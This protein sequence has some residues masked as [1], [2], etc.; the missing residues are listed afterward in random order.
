[1]PTS[2]FS[3]ATHF[4]GIT[5]VHGSLD[6][7]KILE[8]FRISGHGEIKHDET[9]WCAAFVGACLRL[10][11]YRSTGSLA[12]RSYEKFGDDLK[13]EPKRGSIVVFW[14]GSPSADTGHVAFYD[15]DEGDHV[16]VLGG[17][18]GN[19]VTLASFPKSRVLGYRW[20]S[21]I[22]QLPTDTTLPN[23]LAIDPDSAPPHVLGIGG[24]GAGRRR[25][26]RATEI[27]TEGAQGPAVRALQ[28]ALSGQGFQVGEVDGEFG[29][30]TRGAVAEFQRSRSLPAT[31]DADEATLQALGIA[32]PR[33]LVSVREGPPISGGGITTMQP[34]DILKIVV[35][36]L[37][38]SRGAGVAGPTPTPAPGTLGADQLLQAVL[39]ALTGQPQPPGKVDAPLPEAPST[40]PVVLSWID[41]I[42]GGEALAGKKTAL[43]VVAYVILAILQAVGVAGTATGTTATQTGQILTMLIG[44]FGTLGGISKIDRV[45]QILGMIAGRSS[46]QLK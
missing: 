38:A 33:R 25:E 15:H 13:D 17:N 3:V 42:F 21:E 19:A 29:P 34:Q 27:L 23:I 39:T 18:Q 6:N 5:E 30:L 45:L 10:A 44:A 32:P 43:A 36:A 37:I 7:P 20:P 22:A 26:P 4:R 12:A 9:P 2:W 11:G 46:A 16:V 31:G 1:M 35:D 8:M 24:N 14:R 41:K 28:D 40:P